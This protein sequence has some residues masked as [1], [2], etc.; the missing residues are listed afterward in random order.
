MPKQLAVLF[1]AGRPFDVLD[2]WQPV[3]TDRGSQRPMADPATHSAPTADLASPTRPIW[4][5]PNWNYSA[6]WTASSRRTLTG[7]TTR[8]ETQKGRSLSFTVRLSMSPV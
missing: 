3:T 7:F 1:A 5:L 4:P 8:R 2:H 6:S